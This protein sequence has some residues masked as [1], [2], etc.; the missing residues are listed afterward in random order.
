MRSWS[1]LKNSLPSPWAHHPRI[2]LFK[3]SR[4]ANRF[5]SITARFRIL[6]LA[7]EFSNL[8]DAFAKKW[9]QNET[10]RS[11]IEKMSK[12]SR[13]FQFEVCF[14]MFWLTLSRHLGPLGRKQ[15]IH[16][17]VTW[18][19]NLWNL[20]IPISFGFWN[21]EVLDVRFSAYLHEL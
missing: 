11:L 10:K 15:V 17:K 7:F 16:R 6:E 19:A 13:T 20:W 14:H 1:L 21:P 3:K 4:S 5:G 2:W 9:D 8:A 12:F 18:Q